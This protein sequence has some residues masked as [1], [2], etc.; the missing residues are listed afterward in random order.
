MGRQSTSAGAARQIAVE[1][2]LRRD[3][4][5]SIDKIIAAATECIAVD[6]SVAMATIAHVAGVSRVTL[7]SH[8]PTKHELISAAT[9]SLIS[10]VDTHLDDH[11]VD[12]LSA[13]QALQHLIRHAWTALSRH[14]AFAVVIRERYGDV[15]E[16][17][18]DPV[19]RRLMSLIQRGRTEGHFRSDQPLI[20]QTALIEDLVVSAARLA[21]QGHIGES[22]VAGCLLETV[23]AALRP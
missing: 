8:F 2:N 18:R 9:Q 4:Q 14:R 21:N 20:W 1:R 11:R 22:D 16:Q 7:Y 23:M 13:D 19:Q 3:A 6:P 12:H 17:R 15:Y 5:L 10:E